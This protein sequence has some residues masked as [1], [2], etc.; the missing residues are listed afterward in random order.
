MTATVPEGFQ[1]LLK[2]PVPVTITTTMSDG[3]P[4]ASVVW[5]DFDGETIRVSTTRER[6]KAKNLLKRPKATVL[7]FDPE[8]PYRYLEV[9]GEA[10]ISEEDAVGF[11]NRTARAY[12]GKPYYGG[13]KPA[14]DP[15]QQRRVVLEIRPRHVNAVRIA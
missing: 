12:T 10:T 6:Q 15:E 1:D 13:I 9:R 4:Q 2:A 5:C 11:I 7:A 14:D 3:Q 8:N